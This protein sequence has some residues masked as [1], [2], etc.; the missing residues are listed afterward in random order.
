MLG[1]AYCCRWQA[2]VT[3]TYPLNHQSFLQNKI[4]T[5]YEKKKSLIYRKLIQVCPFRFGLLKFVVCWEHAM[6][7]SHHCLPCPAQPC[8][9]AACT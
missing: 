1:G 8:L 2:Q 4:Y 5:R 3:H 6:P 9:F 7:L